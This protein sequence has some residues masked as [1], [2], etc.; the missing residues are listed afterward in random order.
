MKHR[1][2]ETN[3]Y[4]NKQL[5][6][7]TIIQVNNNKQSTSENKRRMEFVEIRYVVEGKR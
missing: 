5:N 7:Y 6:K 4:I 1:K 3:K 2:I